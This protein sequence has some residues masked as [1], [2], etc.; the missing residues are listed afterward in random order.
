MHRCSKYGTLKL[1][2]LG[3]LFLPAKI[4]VIDKMKKKDLHAELVPI[5]SFTLCCQ[6][7]EVV[8]KF[9]AEI[10]D[11][12]NNDND[13]DSWILFQVPTILKD[14]DTTAWKILSI[15]LISICLPHNQDET[16]IL[17]DLQMQ[18]RRKP[19]SMN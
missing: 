13:M 17:K 19:K 2:L 8:D 15:V 11:P 6:Q 18:P 16:A 10:Y 5:V 12:S 7:E 9:Q 3:E 1:A 4:E 14:F